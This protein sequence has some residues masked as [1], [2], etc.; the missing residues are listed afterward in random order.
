MM[1]F[2]LFLLLSVLIWTPH[3]RTIH[4]ASQRAAARSSLV[5]KSSARLGAGDEHDRG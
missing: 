4:S 2:V 5:L 3:N 1:F